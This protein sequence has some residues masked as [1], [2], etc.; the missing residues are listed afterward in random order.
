MKANR[1]WLSISDMMAGLMMVFLF[2]AVVF[3]Q[4]T[5]IKTKIIQKDKDALEIAKNKAESEKEQ[6]EKCRLALLAI[7][8]TYADSKSKLNQALHDEF[9]ADLEKWGAEIL[10]DNTIRFKEI[11]NDFFPRYMRILTNEEFIQDIIELR[12]EGHTSSLWQTASTLHDTYLNNASLSQSRA[13]SVLDYIFKMG[14][15]SVHQKW[16]VKVLRANGLAFARRIFDGETEDKEK[17]QESGVSSNNQYRRKNRKNT[18]RVEIGRQVV[19]QFTDFLNLLRIVESLGASQVVANLRKNLNG[20]GV[21][22]T[23]PTRVITGE[24][25]IYYISP[26]GVLTKVIVH[27]VDISVK[28]RYARE[29]AALVQREQF[30]SDELIKKSH[31]Y[32]LVRCSMLQNN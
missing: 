19:M 8:N 16:L 11:L 29:L 22:L 21:D 6:A 25:G 14:E 30:E 5:E 32:H 28:P 7:A 20:E 4:Q 15:T 24:E 9:D 12:I 1:E 2:I 23:D 27:I 13:F 3:M 17:K 10:F 31:K 18:G 26:E